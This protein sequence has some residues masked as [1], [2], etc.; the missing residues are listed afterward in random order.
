ME[1]SFTVHVNGES[2]QVT[3]MPDT[4]LLWVLRGALGLT[5]TKFGCGSG[6]CGA[7]TVHID[8][9]ARHACDTP[10]WSVGDSRVTTI[11]G[12]AR[13]GD[14]HPLQR[15]IV[16][17]QAMQC[18]Y[19][20]SGIIM[21][22]AVCLN[23]AEQES[24]VLDRETICQELDGHLCRC[25]AHNRMIDAMTRANATMIQSQVRDK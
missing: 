2:H 14:E 22:G 11:E 15:E 8:G 23:K 6:L 16:T 7:C 9:A 3:C 12:L 4:P 18:G 24:R 1:Q 17:S 21:R 25:G 10:I 13:D 20:I 5:G 19:C